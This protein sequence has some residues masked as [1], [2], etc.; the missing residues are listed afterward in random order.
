MTNASAMPIYLLCGYCFLARR[1]GDAKA[2]IRRVD[3]KNDEMCRNRGIHERV[4]TK[5]TTNATN[6]QPFS[7]TR[8]AHC[9]A[10]LLPCQQA[11]AHKGALPRIW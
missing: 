4:Y 8:L 5:N 2:E 7:D 3:K 11:G 9:P 10:S 6:E 1:N